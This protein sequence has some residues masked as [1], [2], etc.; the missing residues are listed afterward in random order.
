M[1]HIC[2]A[3][4][5]HKDWKDGIKD[6]NA[7]KTWFEEHKNECLINHKGS[8]GNMETSGAVDLFSENMSKRGLKYTKFV[9]DGDSSCYGSVAEA[10]E[11]K[12]GLAYPVA[13]EECM[14]HV[15]KRMGAALTTFKKDMKGKRLSDGKVAGGAGRLTAEMIKK[16]Q[17]Y[18]GI[19][20]RQNCGNLDGMRRAIKAILHHIVQDPSKSLEV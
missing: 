16:M 3:C 19:A 18:Y 17:N 7:Y 4:I 5:A 10:M 8:S 2:H 12:F 11:Q 15:Q 6:S 1:S 13:K 14:G 20:I 9:G